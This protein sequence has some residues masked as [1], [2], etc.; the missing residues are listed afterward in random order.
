M[1]SL[2]RYFWILLL[3][4]PRHL[5]PVIRL[6]RQVAEEPL[7]VLLVLVQVAAL[8]AELVDRVDDRLQDG[9]EP[10]G[11]LLQLFVE[12]AV[13]QVVVDVPHRGGSGT[14]AAGT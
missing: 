1:N 2:S 3:V 8:E 5:R 12:G 10:L 13:E 11:Q 6:L 4:F 7:D 9:D 14:S